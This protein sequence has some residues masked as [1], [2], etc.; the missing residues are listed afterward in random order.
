MPEPSFAFQIAEITE[1]LHRLF[2]LKHRLKVVLP[3]D[4]AHLKAQLIASH[5]GGKAG[6]AADYDL[7]YSIG[8]ILSR[9]QEPITM[10]DLSRA[11]D[12]PLSSAT[13]IVDW[14]VK[15]G[16]AE[17]QPDPDDRRI[18]R[19]ALTATGLEMNGAINAFI[20]DRIERWL[21]RFTPEECAVLVPLM[22][23]FV[24]VLEEEE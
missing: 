11:L 21:R 7:F 4:L 8:M 2:H 20:R 19:V 17:R 1:I 10:G 3:E 9:Q 14:L 22:R 13:R 23:K 12:V 18:V 5:P 24:D 15:N 16:Y 6:S